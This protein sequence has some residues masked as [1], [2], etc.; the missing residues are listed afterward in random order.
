MVSEAAIA[1]R[2]FRSVQRRQCVCCGVIPTLRRAVPCMGGG[3]GGVESGESG[4][5]GAEGGE[6]RGQG[7]FVRM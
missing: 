3:D 5:Q 4:E 1:E 6:R 7:A 2:S